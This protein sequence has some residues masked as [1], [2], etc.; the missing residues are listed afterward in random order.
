MVLTFLITKISFK[1]IVGKDINY[2]G[3]KIK[4]ILIKFIISFLLVLV[5]SLLFSKSN[6]SIAEIIEYNLFYL[7]TSSIFLTII[8]TIFSFIDYKRKLIFLSNQEELSDNN[9]ISNANI[10]NDEE[11]K[12][13]KYQGLKLKNILT[14]FILF[15]IFIIIT[16]ITIMTVSS[17]SINVKLG[18]FFFEISIV[19]F[20]FTI[21]ITI[22]SFIFI[23]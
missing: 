15:F 1:E 16:S 10:E 21:I 13:I 19:S 17:Q 12:N 23:K 22:F 4:N 6:N 20:I 18:Q 11:D 9:N 7:I 2:Q 5:L 14:K 3:L 8:I